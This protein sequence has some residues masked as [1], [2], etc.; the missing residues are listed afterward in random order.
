MLSNLTRPLL[1]NC[2]LFEQSCLFCGQRPLKQ[3]VCPSCEA[4][5]PKLAGPHC[6]CCAAPQASDQAPC[7]HCQRRLPAFDTLHAL[8]RYD[9]PLDGLIMRCKYGRQA[10]LQGALAW[11]LAQA[12]CRENTPKYDFI[13]AVPASAQRLS[14]R[15]FN[16]PDALAQT[17][18]ATIGSPLA[19]DWCMRKRNTT[20]QASLDR[21]QRLRNLRD[22]FSVKRSCNGLS[23]AII[24][25]VATTGTT[26]DS[27][28]ATLKKAGA[29]RV[30]G[31]VLARAE[32]HQI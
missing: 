32:M 27:L 5:L 6:P 9:Y 28:A 12:I 21:A 7:G 30:D 3:A 4:S 2:L 19:T 11:L 24:D 8:Y 20:P 15:G 13:I 1:D 26:L 18:A 10:Q 14:E 22:A 29:K 31:W 16:L 25:D 23:L 17:M